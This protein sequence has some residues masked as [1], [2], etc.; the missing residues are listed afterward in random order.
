M[1]KERIAELI[2][3]TKEKNGLLNNMYDITKEQMEEIEKEDMDKLSIIMDRKDSLIKKIDELDLSFVTIFSQIKKDNFI[4]NI[5]DLSL[6]KY[7]ELK[8]LKEAVKEVSSTLMALSLM[9]EKNTQA[10]KDRLKQTKLELR[11]LKEGKK[12]YKGY[13]ASIAESMLIDEK[14]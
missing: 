7:P 6:E 12:A 9:D 3:I 11:K 13:K 4:E 1:T 8:E 2:S 14:K 5:D 10:M